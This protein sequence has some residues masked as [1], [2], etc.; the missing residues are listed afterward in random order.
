MDLQSLQGEIGNCSCM[1]SLAVDDDIVFPVGYEGAVSGVST[2][3]VGQWRA[4]SSGNRNVVPCTV[5][6]SRRKVVSQGRTFGF[7][8]KYLAVFPVQMA[9]TG[10]FVGIFI[11]FDAAASRYPLQFIVRNQ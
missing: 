7:R 3:I 6:F 11:P 4:N 1:H 9:I 8:K 10:H 5:S 2:L